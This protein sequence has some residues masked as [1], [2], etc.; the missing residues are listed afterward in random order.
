MESLE[1][2]RLL[3]ASGPRI[4]IQE[5]QAADGVRLVIQGTQRADM[6]RIDD[7]GTGGKGNLTVTFNGGKTYV[8][9][10]AISTISVNT[11]GGRDHVSYNLTGDLKVRRGLTVELGAGNDRFDAAIVGAIDTPDA[12]AIMAY[13]DA[14]NDQLHVVQTGATLRGT[15][16][17]YL[18][19]NDGDDVIS[20]RG[21]GEIKAGAIVAP[22]LPGDAG[23]DTITAEY[24]GV[25]GGS[26][27]YN[28]TIDGGPGNDNLSNRVHVK[29]GSWGK[30]G[31]D[32]KTPAIIQGGDGD[33]HIDYVI[34][35]ESSASVFEVH[36]ALNAGNGRDTVQRSA[37]VKSDAS[38]ETETIV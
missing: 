23:N 12:L 22:G 5:V 38:S 30:I 26:Y 9:K 27:L 19:G 16:F 8:S 3:S 29:A 13:G 6:I 11:F 21:S 17:P 4:R 35:S 24:S 2:R 32:D 10:R 34:T 25:I 15:F 31:T 33:D 28:L 14:G 37:N 1:G 20:Y 18:Q 36:A 7:N